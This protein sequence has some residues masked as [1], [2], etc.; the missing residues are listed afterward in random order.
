MFV[1]N[2]CLRVVGQCEIVCRLNVACVCLLDHRVILLFD[3]REV[4]TLEG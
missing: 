1:G 3:L 4:H 2:F